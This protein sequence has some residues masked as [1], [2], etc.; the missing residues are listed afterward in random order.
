MTL[1][2]EFW[3]T[4]REA[5]LSLVNALEKELGIIPST[6]EIRKMYREGMK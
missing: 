6:S 1:S 4:I 2:R 5:L 3:M